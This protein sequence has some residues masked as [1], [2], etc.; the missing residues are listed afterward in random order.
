MQVLGFVETYNMLGGISAWISAGYQVV[1]DVKALNELS[2]KTTIY[3][4]P[5]ADYITFDNSNNSDA[6]LTMNIYNIAGILVKEE[7]LTQNLT[8]INTHDLSNGLYTVLI[9]SGNKGA[10]KKLII[11]R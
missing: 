5:A 10:Y 8:Q 9:K 4:N 3:P 6:D 1:T 2:E 7:Q 11:Q